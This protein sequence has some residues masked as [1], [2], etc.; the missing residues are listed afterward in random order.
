VN[1]P[2]KIT[3]FRMILSFGIIILLLFPFYSVN[4]EFPT[5]LVDGK[6]L[7][8]SKYIIAGIAFIIAA[9]TDF[10]DGFIARKYNMVTDF[11]KLMDAIADKVLVNSLLII[12][13]SSN[14][15]SPIIAVIVVM[16]DIIVDSI[17]M[18]AASKG[19]VV[20]AIKSGKIKTVCLMVGISLT[21]FNNLPFELWNIKIS[22]FLLVTA[23]VLSLISAVQYYVMNKNLIVEKEEL[24]EIIEI[25]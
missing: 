12:L 9:L 1:L 15:I 25:L 4:V 11:G 3:V 23:T 18:L 5:Y 21:L 13:A 17:K 16:R 22:D 24:E 7:V 20:A 2:N 19:K 8:D 6:I 10:I 14:H